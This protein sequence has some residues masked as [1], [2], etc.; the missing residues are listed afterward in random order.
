[1]DTYVCDIY[2]VPILVVQTASYFLYG[3][4]RNATIKTCQEQHDQRDKQ[5]SV[6]AVE[7]IIN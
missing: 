7:N 1:M 5:R 6:N 3:I 2:N 4:R